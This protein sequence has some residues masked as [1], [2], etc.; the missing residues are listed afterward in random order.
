MAKSNQTL[1]QN[2]P[3]KPNKPRPDFPLFPHATRRWAKK[4][5]GK[6]H[7]FGPWRDPQGALDR[8]LD[9]KD[10]LYAGRTPRVKG[11]GVTIRDLVN[12]FLTSKKHLLDNG[13]ITD[14][15]F[16]DYYI[17]C[18][19]LIMTFGVNRLAEDLVSEDFDQL[20]AGLAKTLGP[21]ALGNEIGRV[22]VVFKF[23]FDAALVDRPVR[24]GPHFK[25]PSK[26]I[27]R[28]TRH[29]N[30]KRFFEADELQK[31]IEVAPKPLRA[32][33]L[34]GIN[35]GFGQG[36]CSNLPKSAIDFE[37]RWIDYPRP[38]TA[39]ER[40]CPLWPETLDAL[41]DA[42][43]CRPMAGNASDDGLLFLTKYGNRW[44]RTN[45]KGMSIDS[46]AQEIT[47]LLRRLGIKRNRLNFYALRHTFE[48][49]A[50]ESRDQVAVNAIMG[51]V[52]NSMAGQYRERIS[53]ERLR[54]VTD[55]V[56]AWLLK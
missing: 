21:V 48:T 22:R 50:G 25:K 9:Q 7:Y 46:V 18:D 51:Y 45:G 52:D 44:V 55:V 42:L 3:R 28:Q 14:R 17:T 5:R 40:R 31:M 23:A 6:L 34:L 26:R 20:R 19:R 1:T 13:E 35:C 16:R 33:I 8:Y 39:V 56:R 30:G 24:Y 53:D 37:S 32:M 2:N 49:I 11:D 54:A 47:K 41:R 4:I 29:A 15:T 36:D 10:D 43:R 38:K 12:S 27:V